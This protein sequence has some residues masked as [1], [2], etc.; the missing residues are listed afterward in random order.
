MEV[1]SDFGCQI[2]SAIDGLDECEGLPQLP[3]YFGHTV[4]LL[5]VKWLISSRSR[6]D[7]KD[8]LTRAGRLWD[9]NFE[10]NAKFVSPIV[11]FYIDRAVKAIAEVKRLAKKTSGSTISFMKDGTKGTFLWVSN[12]CKGLEKV[13]R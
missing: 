4:T 9:F 13:P 1:A 12:V 2:T 8:R 10:N 7:V 11:E 5:R 6:F 3:D